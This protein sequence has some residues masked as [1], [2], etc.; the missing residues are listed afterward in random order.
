MLSNFSHLAFC[1]ILLPAS[2]C[3]GKSYI[4]QSDDFFDKLRAF[5]LCGT[6]G[7]GFCCLLSAVFEL[8]RVVAVEGREDIALLDGIADFFVQIDACRQVD[9]ILLGCSARTG[10]LRRKPNRSGCDFLHIAIRFSQQLQMMR[11][12]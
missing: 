1:V 3:P 10:M 6:D 9:L 5:R 8:R 4:L 11:S 2:D 12:L 7:K